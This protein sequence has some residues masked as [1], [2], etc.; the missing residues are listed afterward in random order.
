MY[1]ELN[2]DDVIFQNLTK[3]IVTDAGE[4][5]WSLKGAKV[6]KWSRS[7]EPVLRRHRFAVLPQDG[8]A[9]DFTQIKPNKYYVHVY[10]TKIEFAKYDLRSL[11]SRKIARN[12]KDRCGNYYFPRTI[13][14]KRKKTRGD[15]MFVKR[16]EK[17]NRGDNKIMTQQSTRNALK[18]DT[19]SV[20]K[21][22]GNWQKQDRN[23]PAH[24]RPQ[25]WRPPKK[26]K[27]PREYQCYRRESG[28]YDITEDDNRV[29][30]RSK[31]HWNRSP[32]RLE[33]IEI[34]K[35]SVKTRNTHSNR[36]KGVKNY[37]DARMEKLQEVTEELLGMLKKVTS[38]ENLK[39]KFNSL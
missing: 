3:K 39:V 24:N 12:L 6:Y 35:S 16:S 26:S 5:T 25:T 30:Q 27:P 33:G 8:R 7:H 29:S 34:G 36:F 14:L 18:K 23:R 37:E 31:S 4:E 22:A 10:Q 11:N 28:R 1:Y 15:E 13:D 9:S 20:Y 38:M 21:N 17:L 32:D 19:G 2:F